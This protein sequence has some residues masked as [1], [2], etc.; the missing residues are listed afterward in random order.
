MKSKALK[1]SRREWQR[2]II[3]NWGKPG[4]VGGEPWFGEGRFVQHLTPGVFTHVG[5][6]GRDTGDTS[7][8]PIRTLIGITCPGCVRVAKKIRRRID[9]DNAAALAKS[10]TVA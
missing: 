7:S 4:E 6:C 9:A 10:R 2:L 8:E 5:F 1:V 3:E